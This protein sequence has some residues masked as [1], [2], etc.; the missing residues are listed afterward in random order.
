MNTKTCVACK[1]FDATKHVC[2]DGTPTPVTPTTPTT[3]PITPTT[4][5]VPTT[6]IVQPVQ[7]ITNLQNANGILLPTNK[8]FL[9]YS[10]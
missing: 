8:N 9:D 10:K 2:L 7:R 4:P 1:N 3:T 5:T 6:P